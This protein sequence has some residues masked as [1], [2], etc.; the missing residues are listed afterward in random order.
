MKHSQRKKKGKSN[1]KEAEEMLYKK[2]Y[3]LQ[4]QFD[5]FYGTISNEYEIA[6]K[7]GMTVIDHL[8]EAQVIALATLL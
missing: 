3:Y 5:G 1:M 2:G 4:N 7:T 6:D 8:S